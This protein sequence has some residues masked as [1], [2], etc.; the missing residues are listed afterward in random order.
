MHARWAGLPP[1]RTRALGLIATATAAAA[2]LAACGSGSDSNGAASRDSVTV[3]IASNPTLDPAKAASQADA[4][5][6]GGLY[7]TLVRLDDSGEVVAGLASSWK[8]TP[9][10][11]ALELRDDV[12]CSDGT[13]LTSDVSAP[14]RA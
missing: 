10:S 7:D 6:L 8:T 11:A 14:L 13:K 3:A 4:I 12:T 1:G 2:L 5:A 9:S